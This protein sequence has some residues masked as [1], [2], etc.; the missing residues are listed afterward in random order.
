MNIKKLVVAL[1]CGTLILG[2]CSKGEGYTPQQDDPKG[3]EIFDDLDLGEGQDVSPSKEELKYNSNQDYDVGQDYK[4]DVTMKKPAGTFGAFATLRS[5]L[6]ATPETMLSIEDRYGNAI[7]IKAETAIDEKGEEYYKISPTSGAFEE[8]AIMSCKLN[9]DAL[10]FKDRD[11]ELDELFFNIERPESS[12]FAISKNTAFFDIYQVRYYPIAD[13]DYPAIDDPRSDEAANF[14]NSAT[15]H[16]GYALPL[17]LQIDQQFGVAI[18]KNGQVDL[19]HENTFYGKFVSEEKEGDHY[20]VTFKNADISEIF[21]DDRSGDVAFNFQQ[22]E[23]RAHITNIKQVATN[24]QIKKNLYQNPDFLCLSKAIAIATD[25]GLPEILNLFSVSLDTSSE[26]DQ[27][28]FQLKI[29]GRVPYGKPDTGGQ[30]PNAIQVTITFQWTISFSCDG[31]VK[32]KKAFGIPYDIDAHGDVTKTTDFKFKLQIAWMKQVPKEKQDQEAEKDVK[33]RIKDAY[34]KLKE[35]KD[36]FRPADEDP[37]VVTGN[38]SSQDILVFEIPFGYVFSFRIALSVDIQMDL[39]VMLSYGYTSHTVERILSFD[40]DDGVKNTSNT[41]DCSAASH[42]IDLGGTYYY[43]CGLRLTISIGIIGLRKLFQ[44]GGSVFFGVFFDL[45]AMGG[46]TWGDNQSTHFY[47]GLE[48]SMGFVGKVTVFLDFLFVFHWEY[49]FANEKW[50]WFTLDT[51]TSIME[52]LAQDVTLTKYSTHTDETD[53]LLV[54]Q[55]STKD[56]GIDLHTYHTNDHV[57]YGDEELTPVYLECS[58]P[59]LTIDNSTSTLVVDPNTAPAEFDTQIVITMNDKLASFVMTTAK[60]ITVNVH[61]QSA[62]AKR[63]YFG[64]GNDTSILVEPGKTISLPNPT[65]DRSI[66]EEVEF[67]DI[68]YVKWGGTPYFTFHV[69]LH[70]YDFLYYTDG[71]NRYQGADTFV[72]PDHDVHLTVGLYKIVYYYVSFFNGNDELL[73]KYEV[74]EFSGSAEPTAEERSMDGWIFYG[75]DRD[76]SYVTCDMEVHGIYVSYGEVEVA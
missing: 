31:G 3:A 36:Y 69:N 62:T 72:M 33:D 58:S 26:D 44:I 49:N 51:G 22:K 32:I 34:S 7:E 23:E 29:S 40:T 14:F 43:E 6:L 50:P 48:F 39:N 73:G 24:E 47:G 30:K 17:N 28:M 65:D 13:G 61:F 16:F 42:S 1:M 71:I 18:V 9:H 63:L 46:V 21:K 38:T 57:T 75:W 11:P 5:Q 59:Y 74:R 60:S 4:V 35:S 20:K 52:L 15:Y 8:G 45:K 64:E 55:F 19:S 2:G 56:F 54:R 12:Y 27:F 70:T 37:E 67:K 76:F 10:G 68:Q 66:D 53:L 41:T 25:N